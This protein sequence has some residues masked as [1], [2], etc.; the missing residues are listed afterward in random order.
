MQIHLL[1]GFLGSGKTTA[2]QHAANILLQENKKIGVITND[3]GKHLVDGDFFKTLGLPNRQVI[4]GCFCCNYNQ[5]EENIQSL[6][7]TNNI[8]VLFAESVGSCTD[9][10]ATV[11]KPL[12]QQRPDASL[13]VS[14]FADIRLLQMMLTGKHSFDKTIQYIFLKQLEE[15]SIIVINKIDLVD[16]EA[17]MKVKELMKENYRNKILVY[18]NSLEDQ[19]VIKWLQILD[20]DK[21][22][23]K[24]AKAQSLNIDYDIYAEGETKLAWFDQ[25]LEV[26]SVTNNALL[27]IEHLINNIHKKIMQRRY[28]IGHLKFLVNNKQKVSFISNTEPPVLLA[29]EQLSTASLLINV[30]VQATPKHIQTIIE[31]TM[32][33]EE[34]ASGCK[35]IVNSFAAFRPRYP[36][37]AYRM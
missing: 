11:L 10:V 14:T 7:D 36:K 5:L 30:R 20:T 13:T 28:S 15:A 26:Y 31:E 16:K 33:E 18:Q 21:I 1:S 29:R 17:L 24:S 23:K 4:N 6:I 3:Q 2:V 37:P 25:S 27:H 19:S 8:N 35:I 34:K 22:K 12:L 9:I 32:Q